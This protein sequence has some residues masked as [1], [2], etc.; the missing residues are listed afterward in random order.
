MYAISE[1]VTCAIV[2]FTL[3]ALLFGLCVVFLAIEQSIENR[4]G[5]PRI[6]QKAGTLLG[7]RLAPVV[8]RHE[9]LE[10]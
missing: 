4:W 7:A 6:F 2:T 9:R 5:T 1:C 10:Q 3:S 8:A